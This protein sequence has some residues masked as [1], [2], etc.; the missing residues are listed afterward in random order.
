VPIETES[1]ETLAHNEGSLSAAM[2][3]TTKGKRVNIRRKAIEHYRKPGQRIVCVYCGFGI[4]DVLEVAH[5]DTDRT[6]NDHTNWAF[7]CPTCHRM[8]DLGLIPTQTIRDMRDQPK[9]VNWRLLMK[10]AGAKAAASRRT[11][12]QKQKRQ[13]A[14]KKAV[15]TRRENATNNTPAS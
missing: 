12:V 3:L 9:T 4:E 10:D 6:N 1:D 14:A 7:L 15:A 2:I 11:T 8:H 5:L 13:M